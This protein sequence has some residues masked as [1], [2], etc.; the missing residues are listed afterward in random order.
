MNDILRQYAFMRGYMAKE[1]LSEQLVKSTSGQ[2]VVEGLKDAALGG[3]LGAGAGAVRNLIQDDPEEET[4]QQKI[5]RYLKNVL[6]GGAAGA[7]I[8][9]GMGLY[10]GTAKGY[11]AEKNRSASFDSFKGGESNNKQT[12]PDWVGK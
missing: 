3:T 8:G 9:L 2:A 5:K 11:N 6:T 1:A 12:D 10:K 7:G 4:N